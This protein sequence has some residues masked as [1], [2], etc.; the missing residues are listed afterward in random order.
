VSAVVLLF[1]IKKKETLPENR[2]KKDKNC[3]S[4]SFSASVVLSNYGKR[5]IK[6]EK[7]QK[8]GVFL[9]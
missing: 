4:I 8:K 7:M 6:S 1:S 2:E 9:L 3:F 5:E